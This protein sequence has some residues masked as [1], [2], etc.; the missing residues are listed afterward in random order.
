[1]APEISRTATLQHI[2][3][4]TGHSN[5]DFEG[6]HCGISRKTGVSNHPLSCSLEI[7]APPDVIPAICRLDRWYA[8]LRKVRPA[9]R[10]CRATAVALMGPTFSTLEER[11]CAN[12]VNSD[13]EWQGVPFELTVQTHSSCVRTDAGTNE[14]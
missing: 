3:R 8:C 7:S 5:L 11:F 4:Q 10:S 12:N 6:S 13:D 14:P 2:R 1:M 9:T